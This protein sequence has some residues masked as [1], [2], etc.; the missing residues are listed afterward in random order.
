MTQTRSPSPSPFANPRLFFN[1]LGGGLTLLSL[2]LPWL[3][4]NGFYQS[5]TSGLYLLAMYW[6]LAGS[7]LSFLTQ[8]AG[9]MTVIGMFGF[10]GEPYLSY[11]YAAGPGI[12]IAVFGAFFTL[13]GVRWSI[14][15][16][17][18][19]GREILGGL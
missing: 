1:I 14:P 4:I 10:L 2:Q 6:I 3:A 17:L 7:L 18:F 15:S 8:Y 19:R 5:G 9:L 16:R 11:G 13:L 12:V